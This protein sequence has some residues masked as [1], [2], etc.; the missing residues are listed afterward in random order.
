MSWVGTDPMDH[1]VPSSLDQVLD[2]IVQGPIQ[3]GH[4]HL[5]GQGI[6]SLSEQPVP[7]AHH[8]LS[9]KLPSDIYSKSQNS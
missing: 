9:R 8:S 2:Q 3:P 6:H 5:Q 7:A 4:K 1:Q